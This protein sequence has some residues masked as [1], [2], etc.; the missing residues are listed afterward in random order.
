MNVT[1]LGSGSKG[2]ALVV[3]CGEE[4]V[5]VD[6]GFNARELVRRL[7]AANIEPRSISSLIVTHE[8]GDHS[9]GARVAAK[10]FG[11][12]VYATAGTIAKTSRLREVQP[13]L[14]S[15]R[16][17]LALETMRVH[18]VRTPH[19]AMEPIALVVESIRDGVRCGIAYDL[20]HVPLSVERALSDLDILILESN[21]DEALLRDGNYPLSLKRRISGGR[22]HLSNGRAAGLLQRLVHRG[23]QHVVLAHL[24]E[25]NNTPQLALEAATAAGRRARLRGKVTVAP[26]HHLLRVGATGGSGSQQMMLEL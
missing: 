17:T 1:V 7:D 20:G 21:H 13:I 3:Q 25:E 8:H 11:W 16:E 4:R 9:C 26:Q 10:R 2:N 23:L 6:A 18:A 12:T 22:G 15:T 24:S 14:I 19:D 5:L